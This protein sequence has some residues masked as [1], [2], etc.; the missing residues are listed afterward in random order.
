M[1]HIKLHQIAYSEQILANIESGYLA[2]DITDNPRADWREYY[3]IRS[4][5]LNERLDE[6]CYYGFFSPKFQAKT[7]LSHSQA[8]AF[9]QAAPAGTDVITFSPQADMGAF[10]LNVFEQNELFDPGF[11]Q[12]SEDLLS[13][14]GMPL[15]LGAMIM[16]SRQIVYS[17]FFVARPAFW[18]AWLAI[19]EHMYQICEGGDSPL[20]QQLCHQTTYQGIERKVFLMERIASLLLASDTRWQVSAYNTFACA[21]SATRLNQFRHEAVVS[22]ALKIAMKENPNV[23]HY[24]AAFTKIRDTLR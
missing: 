7:G 15:K 6:E 11:T 1:R 3:P 22:D 18:K 17:N 19:N 14:L 8:I 23:G 2:L 21:W 24:L 12:A 20:K 5:L 16:D 4:F 10:F 13:S 9:I